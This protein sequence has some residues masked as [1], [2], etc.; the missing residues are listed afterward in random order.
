MSTARAAANQNVCYTMSFASHSSMKEVQD[1]SGGNVN[2]RNIYPFSSEEGEEVSLRI[3]RNAEKYGMKALG[4]HDL[5]I[6]HSQMLLF[7]LC[8]IYIIF[9]CYYKL[10]YCYYI[11]LSVHKLRYRKKKSWTFLK[12]Q[13]SQHYVKSFSIPRKVQAFV[14]GPLRTLVTDHCMLHWF[15][16]LVA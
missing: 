5:N 1:V 6:L 14:L 7:I 8:K 4:K 16:A 2:W 13:L 11:K 9:T 10:W 12:F 3:I 15:C